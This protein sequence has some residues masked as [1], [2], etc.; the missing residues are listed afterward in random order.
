MNIEKID[1][2]LIDNIYQP[3]VDYTQLKPL[4]LGRFCTLL[5][6]I[7]VSARYAFI[8]QTTNMPLAIIWIDI[9]SSLLIAGGMYILSSSDRAF[10][11]SP[12]IFRY[13]CLFFLCI[14]T[15]FVIT[16]SDFNDLCR[17]MQDLATTSFFFL[18][19]CKYPKPPEKKVGNLSFQF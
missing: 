7:F 15:F 13:T 4:V 10:A 6:A 16:Q 2:F 1:R 5:Y 11:G 8:D 3:I 9:L 12:M 17:F 19:C 14:S 18:M